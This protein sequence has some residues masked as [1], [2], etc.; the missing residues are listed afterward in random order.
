MFSKSGK[1]KRGEWTPEQYAYAQRCVEFGCI[2]C[3][4]GHGIEGSPAMWH[5]QKEDYHGAGMRAPHHH[6]L[7][8]CHHHHLGS[9]S[10]SVHLNPEGFRRLIGMSEAE[11]V[12]WCWERFGWIPSDP[13]SSE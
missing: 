9:T 10:E 1:S 11:A 13:A 8:L 7:P 2:A 12:T 5:H 4:L 6:G 3:Y